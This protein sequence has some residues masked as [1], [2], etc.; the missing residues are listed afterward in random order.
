MPKRI[1]WHHRMG[2]LPSNTKSVMRPSR[3]GHPFPVEGG[4]TPESHAAAVA[5]FRAW[6]MQP[7]QAKLRAAAKRELAGKDLACDCKSDL[8]CH[9]D[10]WLEIAND[11]EA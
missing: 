4:H 1:R 6:L 11:V 10:V 7:E 2:P 8:P 3:W 9:A 5:K